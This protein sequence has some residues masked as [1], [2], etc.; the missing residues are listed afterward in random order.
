MNIFKKNKKIIKIIKIQYSHLQSQSGKFEEIIN[1]EIVNSGYFDLIYVSGN[2]LILNESD[3]GLT[4]TGRLGWIFD[5][6]E[7]KFI[8]NMEDLFKC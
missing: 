6:N 3:N 1:K 2:F 5:L 4:K 8:K 7:Y